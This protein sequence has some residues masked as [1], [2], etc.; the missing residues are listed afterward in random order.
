MASSR[1]P[2]QARRRPRAAYLGPEK[3]RPLVLGAALP[4]FAERGYKGT[5]MEMIAE[6]A[7]VTKPVLYECFASKAGLFEALLEQEAARFRELLDA[8]TPPDVDPGDTESVNVAGMVSFL[9][10][11]AA[12]PES[13]RVLTQPLGIG[14]DLPERIV[15]RGARIQVE[16]IQPLAERVLSSR[17]VKDAKRKSRVIAAAMVAIGQSAA[18]LMIERPGDW[19]PVELGTLLGR[20]IVRMEEAFSEPGSG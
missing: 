19:D 2:D 6:A 18:S 20:A 17:G 5:S 7:G 10:A 9:S 11:V 8:H 13:W 12:S 1:A 16:Q 14:D 15:D 4:I 3:R